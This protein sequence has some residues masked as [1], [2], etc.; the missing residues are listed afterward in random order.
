L[1]L[2]RKTGLAAITLKS[3]LASVV[4]SHTQNATA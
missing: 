4:L 1:S 3:L 2:F